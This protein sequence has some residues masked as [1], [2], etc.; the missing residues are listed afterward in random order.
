MEMR[1]VRGSGLARRVEGNDVPSHLW[2][3]PGYIEGAPIFAHDHPKL[4][5]GYHPKQQV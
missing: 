2:I 5:D 3:G 4:F 1:F